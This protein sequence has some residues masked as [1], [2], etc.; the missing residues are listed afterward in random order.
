[1]IRINLLPVRAA[2]KRNTS[3]IQLATMA[4]VITATVLALMT[5]N[6]SFDAAVE[7]LE[8]QVADRNAEVNRLKRV[9]GE[10]KDLEDEKTALT[11]QLEVINKLERGRRGPVHVLDELA[12]VIPKRVWLESFVEDGG[13]VVMGGY[14][15][16]NAD[17]SEFMKALQK[18]KYFKRINLKF[19]E[20]ED[21]E[22][23]NIYTFE[24]HLKVDYSA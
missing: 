9:I 10:V 5:W 23:V 12:S 4:A 1:M 21:R 22:G 16:E 15:L 20:V 14:G 17:I 13:R 18:S 19:T 2:K 3:L 7:D 8:R 11:A 24:I 6:S